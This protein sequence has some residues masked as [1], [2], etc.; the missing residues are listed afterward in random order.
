[1]RRRWMSTASTITNSTP[2]TIR[3]R[4][5]LSMFLSP[6]HSVAE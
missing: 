6:F 2:A 1:V 3:I 5:T 4:V